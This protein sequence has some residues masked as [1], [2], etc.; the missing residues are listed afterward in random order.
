M[1]IG[2]R[3]RNSPGSMASSSYSRNHSD[4]PTQGVKALRVAKKIQEQRLERMD[5]AILN[6][7]KEAARLS[8][9]GNTA[10]NPGKG[11]DRGI[12]LGLLN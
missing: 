3:S 5:S 9:N 2:I 1:S 6:I 10:I 8:F 11:Q 4:D 7:Q 12:T